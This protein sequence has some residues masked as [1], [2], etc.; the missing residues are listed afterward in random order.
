MHVKKST[1]QL[2]IN[3]RKPITTVTTQADPLYEHVNHLTWS[4]FN[5]VTGHEPD[6]SS[7]CRQ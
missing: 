7:S 5:E 3:G 1:E 6:V 2:Q 4:N